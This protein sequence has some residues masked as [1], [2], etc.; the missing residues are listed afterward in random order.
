[1]A[2]LFLRRFIHTLVFSSLPFAVMVTPAC[3]GTSELVRDASGKPMFEL[4][5]FDQRERYGQ[6]ESA[7]YPNVSSWTL[8]AAQKKAV[9]K[10]VSLWADILGPGS[11]NTA[12]VA[13]N[14]GTFDD[15]NADAGSVQNQDATGNAGYT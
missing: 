4:H 3:A 9:G 11:V 7:E 8:D 15:E 2:Y 12:P 5:F 6:Y 10:A 1:M 14:I 13:I